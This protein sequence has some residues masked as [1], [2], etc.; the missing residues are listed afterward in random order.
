MILGIGLLLLVTQIDFNKFQI[1]FF[2]FSDLLIN[3]ND[4]KIK[5]LVTYFKYGTFNP[6]FILF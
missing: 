6:I 1:F 4:P 2:I 5:D 3:A